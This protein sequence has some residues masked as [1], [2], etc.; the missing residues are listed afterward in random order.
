[1][2]R[3]ASP[4]ALVY[5]GF[6]SCATLIGVALGM[7]EL[8]ALAAPLV[9]VVIGGVVATTEPSVTIDV[10]VDKH[11]LVEGDEVGVRISV[12]SERALSRVDVFV[13]VPSGRGSVKGA[14]PIALRLRPNETQEVRKE[15]RFR[16]WGSYSLGRTIVRVRGR[17]GLFFFEGTSPDIAD[18]NVYPSVGRLANLIRPRETQAFSG[19]RLSRLRGEGIEFADIRPFVAGD[20]QRRIN[21][22]LSAKRAELWVTESHT[23]RN[24]DVVIFLDSFTDVVSDERSTLEDAVRGICGLT[25]EYLRFR[26]R[27]GLISFG[28]GLTWVTPSGGLRHAYRV[29]DAILGTKVESSAAWRNVGIVPAGTLPPRSLIV[30]FS[31]LVDDRPITALMEL[32]SRGFDVAIVELRPEQYLSKPS[33]EDEALA[34]RIWRL[35]RDVL[36]GHFARRGVAVVPWN[37]RAGLDVVMQRAEIFRRG[38]MRG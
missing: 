2:K 34:Q 12:S 6:G 8:I 5:A 1:M 21:W 19:N 33:S 10:G 16:R 37:G 25:S 31:P 14:N 32:R 35:E 29:V 13:V 27:V 22:R 17:F 24:S 15:V 3:S 23:E 9:L 36:R 18:I 30:A 4:K 20:Q 38:A 28:A 26:D 11:R 7:P